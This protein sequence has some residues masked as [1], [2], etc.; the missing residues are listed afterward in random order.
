MVQ[1]MMHYGA[2]S[3]ARDLLD[4][5]AYLIHW[6]RDSKAPELELHIQLQLG[7]EWIIKP[8]I[9]WAANPCKDT[10]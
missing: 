8:Q 1:G 2:D 9:A 3:R 10:V 6:G 4:M 5:Q 7:H